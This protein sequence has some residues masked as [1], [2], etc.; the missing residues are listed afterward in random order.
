MRRGGCG[1]GCETPLRN[2]CA[3][4]S[5]S[6]HCC[7]RTLRPLPPPH[8]GDKWGKSATVPVNEGGQRPPR[9]P[10]ASAHSTAA[11]LRGVAKEC[12]PPRL[13]ETGWPPRPPR[14]SAYC[15]R[16]VA[17]T[18]GETARPTPFLRGRRSLR[19]RLA[20]CPTATVA[21]RHQV[22]EERGLSRCCWGGE[23]AVTTARL[24]PLPL[25][26]LSDGWW[27][28]AADFVAVGARR[29]WRQQRAPTHCPLRTA[30]TRG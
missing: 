4:T 3:A 19:Y 13:F 17:A 25:P 5:A 26:R 28:S 11:V 10:R 9:P 2:R 21:P 30:A 6:A 14:A 27:N 16:F 12:G 23:A 20:P 1:T 18:R 15:H 7:C 22:G 24:H 29:P 8:S